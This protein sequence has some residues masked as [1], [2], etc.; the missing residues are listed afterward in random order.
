LR[1]LMRSLATAG[2]VAGWEPNGQVRFPRTTPQARRLSQFYQDGLLIGPEGCGSH[3]HNSKAA[4][5]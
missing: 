2:V 1:K 5:G 3:R 4:L